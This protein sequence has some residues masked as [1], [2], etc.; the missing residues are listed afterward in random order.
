L[1]DLKEKEVEE[2]FEDGC[3]NCRHNKCV[4]NE[5]ERHYCETYQR[6]VY[7]DFHEKGEVRNNMGGEVMEECWE[8][9][10]DD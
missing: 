5:D 4:Q 7:I 10:L 2:E 6:L 3:W 9:E 8:Q 1:V